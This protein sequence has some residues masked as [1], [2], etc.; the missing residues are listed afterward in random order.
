MTVTDPATVPTGHVVFNEEHDALRASIRAFVDRE[1][2]PHVAEWEENTFPDSIV[3]RMGDLGLL[4][5]SVPE[6]YGGQGGDYFT[7]LVLAE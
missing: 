6:E 3:R 2:V 1:I 4:G 7:N 5:L